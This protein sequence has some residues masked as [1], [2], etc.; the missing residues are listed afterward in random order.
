M[1][2]PACPL[3]TIGLESEPNSINKIL[4]EETPKPKKR[5]SGEKEIIRV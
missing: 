5:E 3:R 1:T 4:S 2:C